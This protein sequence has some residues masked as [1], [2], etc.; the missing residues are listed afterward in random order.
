MTDHLTENARLRAA[1]E[2][3]AEVRAAPAGDKSRADH[4]GACGLGWDG[5]YSR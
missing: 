3:I 1:L 4:V 5:V 2:D